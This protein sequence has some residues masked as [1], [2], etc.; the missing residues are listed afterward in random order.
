MAHF[1]SKWYKNQL[2]LEK[3]QLSKVYDDYGEAFTAPMRELVNKYANV[4]TKPSKP[5]AREIKHK[6][7][8]LDPE[9]PIPYHVI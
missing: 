4:F 1:N 5:V 6:T 2:E 3:T 9:K 7:E 8:L